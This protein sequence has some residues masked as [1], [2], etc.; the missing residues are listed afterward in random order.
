MTA[1]VQILLSLDTIL[2][3]LNLLEASHSRDM[4]LWHHGQRVEAARLRASDPVADPAIETRRLREQMEADALAERYTTRIEA[5]N[6]LLP[7]AWRLL[8]AGNIDRAQMYAAAARKRGAED[9]TFDREVNRLLDATVPHRRQA[10]E[11]EVTAAD[12]LELSRRDVAAQRLAHGIGTPVELVRASNAV[13]M[14]DYKRQQEAPVLKEQLG[15]ELPTV[16]D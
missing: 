12:E 5:Q 6:H 3:E 14:H 9:G 1:A 2:K 10:V 15:I 13:K 8:N 7:E 4:L 11:V 16:T